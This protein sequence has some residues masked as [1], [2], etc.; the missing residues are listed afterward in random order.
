LMIFLLAA[1]DHPFRGDLSV[2]PHAF[3]MVYE[4]LMKPGA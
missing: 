3:Q 4:Q 2:T 1:M